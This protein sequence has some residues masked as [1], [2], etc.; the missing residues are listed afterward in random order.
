MTA[1]FQLEDVTVARGGRIVLREVSLKICAGE[2]LALVG[3]YTKSR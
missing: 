3:D 2:K 1:L